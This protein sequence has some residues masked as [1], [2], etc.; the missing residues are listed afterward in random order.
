MRKLF[1]LMALVMALS[2]PA[3]AG[4]IN[5]DW[6]TGDETGW[7][8]WWAPW[9][10]ANWAVTVNGPWAPEGTA[11]LDPGQNGSFGWYQTVECPAG[12]L[13]CISGLW[14]GSI[15]GAGWAEVMLWT[16][17]APGGEANRADAGNP[18]D[19]AF[20]KDSWGMN[21]PTTWEWQPITLSP[22][23]QGNGGMVISQGYVVVALKL[24]GFSPPEWVSWDNLCLTCVPE[25]GSMLALGTGLVGLAGFVIRRRK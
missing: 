6:S 22:H 16:Q 14:A 9:G 10:A 21:P 4:L 23:P 7:T 1:V 5:G 13:C 24:G 11:T 15:G 20:K 2:V 17:A 19:I 25:P 3:A 8:R 18:A 12:M